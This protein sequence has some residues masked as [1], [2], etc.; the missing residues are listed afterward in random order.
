MPKKHNARQL[1]EY[2][3]ERFTDSAPHALILD[4]LT[5][6]L[7]ATPGQAARAVESAKTLIV[8]A[9]DEDDY[10]LIRA[11]AFAGDSYKQHFYRLRI[12]ELTAEQERL[13]DDRELDT[14]TRLRLI[15]ACDRSMQ[16]WSTL[17]L[18]GRRDLPVA[19]APKGVLQNTTPPEDADIEKA[20]NG[21]L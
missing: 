10:Q 19:F 3:I 5:R 15:L 6:E 7:G 14:E 11:C 4:E 20:I 12:D 13:K 2:A 16:G 8:R 21:A 1:Q 18:R 17:S 9:L